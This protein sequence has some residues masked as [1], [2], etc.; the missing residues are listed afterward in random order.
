MTSTITETKQTILVFK[1]NINKQNEN[2]LAQFLNK[3]EVLKWNIDFED[4]DKVLR[5]VTK[6][7]TCEEIILAAKQ[8]G[9]T[10]AELE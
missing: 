10:C 8:K 7:L 6:S 1:T 5:I 3:P 2:K 4:C 9:I